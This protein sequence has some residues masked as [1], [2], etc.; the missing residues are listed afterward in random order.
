MSILEEINIFN[1]KPHKP[2]TPGKPGAGSNRLMTIL[3]KQTGKL[4]IPSLIKT[5]N[6][7]NYSQ[8]ITTS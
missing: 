8:S 1:T 4:V 3:N 7:A 6:T 5:N 2:S